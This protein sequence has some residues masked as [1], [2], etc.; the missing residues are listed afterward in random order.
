[1]P[2]TQNLRDAKCVVH[3]LEQPH[4][5]DYVVNF[6]DGFQHSGFADD[7]STAADVIDFARKRIAARFGVDPAKLDD[8]ITVAPDEFTTPGGM[9][10]TQVMAALAS[11]KEAKAKAVPPAPPSTPTP[12]AP[13]AA[14]TSAPAPGPNPATKPATPPTQ[15]GAPTPVKGVTA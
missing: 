3:K 14:S 13:P 5:F 10:Y 2:L 12:P 1:M 11:W 7:K 6:A 4:R 9:D 8:F 15:V